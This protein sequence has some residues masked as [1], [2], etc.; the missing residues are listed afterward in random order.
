MRKR[1]ITFVFVLAFLSVSVFVYT[2]NTQKVDPSVTV[3][4]LV[5]RVKSGIVGDE[6][7]KD[8]LKKSK[9]S[10]LSLKKANK[11]SHS[12]LA[13]L[14]D[15]KMLGRYAMP[16]KFWKTV[17]SPQQQRYLSI[18]QE[19]IEE[20]VY[21]QSRDF[22]DKVS[23]NYST[24]VYSKDKKTL[25]IE[26]IV[27]YKKKSG[28]TEKI[29]LVFYLVKSGSTWKIYDAKIEEELWTDMFKNQFNHI[30]TNN[31]YAYLLERMQKKLDS[32]KNGTSI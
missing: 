25:H 9:D 2:A 32:V 27:D 21:P 12:K 18:L 29:D 1:L 16:K 22:F 11:R 14:I 19:L 3:K 6:Q 28:E 30:I 13:K 17:K 10:F 15:F 24:P 23:L 20:I 31:S 7:L 8:T 26:L 4:E 5:S